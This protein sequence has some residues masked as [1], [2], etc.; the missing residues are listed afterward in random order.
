MKMA[1]VKIPAFFLYHSLWV[2]LDWLF[3]PVCGGC[4]V[5]GQRWCYSCQQK[6]ERIP[7]NI[8]KH[9]GDLLQSTGPLCPKCLEKPPIFTALRSW[10]IYSGPLRKAIHRLK[11]ENDIG[12]GEGLS[13]HLI[14]LYNQLKWDVD[15]VVPVPLGAGRLKHRGYNQSGLLARPFAYAI[16]KPYSPGLLQRIRETRTQVGLTITERQ[17][18]VNNAFQARNS[19]VSGKVVL[20]IDDVTTTGSTINACAKALS[21]AGASAVYGM[22]L[23]RPILQADADDQPNQTLA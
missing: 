4:D 9:C 23:A 5:P 17:L 12:L 11:Y 21:T 19:Q 1:G 16:E 3:P 7:S 2:A 22:T 18:N 15:I 6:A 13:K 8:C 20:L 14:E 10:G